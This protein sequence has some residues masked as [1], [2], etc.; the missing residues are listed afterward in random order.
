MAVITV[1]RV[2]PGG[3]ALPELADPLPED[4]VDEPEPPESDPDAPDPPDPALP[5][6]LDPHG[7]SDPSLGGAGVAGQAV[8]SPSA[9]HAAPV[10]WMTYVHPLGLESDTC[11]TPIASPESTC[12]Q[13]ARFRVTSPK[14]ALVQ[15]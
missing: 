6:P 11:H 12:A 5:A 2:N 14:V 13:N 4:D 7:Q 10:N 9:L 3:H 15:S 8:Q 1:P